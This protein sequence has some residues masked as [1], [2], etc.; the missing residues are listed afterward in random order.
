MTLRT[1]SIL[2]SRL[3]LL[4]PTCGLLA[5]L[6]AGSA[7]ATDN[8]A[9]NAPAA[10]DK[11]PFSIS[12]G[13]DRQKTRYQHDRAEG[14]L[15]ETTLSVTPSLRFADT[16]LYATLIQLEDDY[17]M[18]IHASPT[19]PLVLRGPN[20]RPLVF[21]SDKTLSRSQSGTGDASVG[22]SQDFYPAGD[23]GPVLLVLDA[24]AK[25][26]NGDEKS[27]L[28]TGS[29]DYSIQ[30]TLDWTP[31]SILDISLT[32][33]HTNKGDVPTSTASAP[34]PEDINY[35]T[36]E[37]ALLPADFL[38]LGILRNH[39]DSAYPDSQ[40]D[41]DETTAYIE[42]NIKHHVSLQLSHSRDQQDSYDSRTMT[43]IAVNL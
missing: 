39:Q 18:T 35:H 32:A 19:N 20:G 4:T 31:T 38:R 23:D 41:S 3:L 16:R 11:S 5:T 34:Q 27:G 2:A 7:H 8:F 30:A 28:G 10:D 14:E 9:D 40:Q 24:H 1:T 12:F 21:Y 25:L 43:S 26:D 37:L 22:I 42:F 33:G 17:S 6:L 36:I 15:I 29:K 13:M